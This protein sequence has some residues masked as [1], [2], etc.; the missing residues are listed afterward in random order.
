M[1]EIV[2]HD[3]ALFHAESSMVWKVAIAPVLLGSCMPETPTIILPISACQ[4]LHRIFT[5]MPYKGLH[6]SEPVRVQLQLTNNIKTSDECHLSDNQSGTILTGAN[7]SPKKD[8]ALYSSSSQLLQVGRFDSCLPIMI[9]FR[10][11]CS[12]S[13]L[14]TPGKAATA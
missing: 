10:F 12:L 2:D 8:G 4:T 14:K 5:N 1:K 7:Q 13:T 3:H 11:F 9:V 6:H